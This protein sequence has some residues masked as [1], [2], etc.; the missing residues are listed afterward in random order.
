MYKTHETSSTTSRRRLVLIL[1]PLMLPSSER[2]LCAAPVQPAE[3]NCESCS[4]SNT[5][6]QEGDKAFVTSPS[7]LRV[8][9]IRAGTGE[10]PT[11]GHTCVVDWVGYTA[12]YQAKRIESSRETDKPFVF[13][14]GKVCPLNP[15]L[16]FP[17]STLL[18]V[19]WW[20]A[21]FDR[22]RQSQRLRRQ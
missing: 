18:P 5:A 13:T 10:Q 11:A 8:L 17:P 7:G 19:M 16:P 22:G 1:A 6:M 4:N 12:G 14:L 9:E 3:S 21:L 20:C 2:P 15:P